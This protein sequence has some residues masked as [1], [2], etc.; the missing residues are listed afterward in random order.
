MSPRSEEAAGRHLVLVGMMA[1]GKTTVGSRLARRLERRFVDSDDQVE[2]RTGRTVRQ[3]FEQDGEDAFR[4]HEAEALAEALGAEEPA[5]I[6]AAGGTVLDEKNR[7][8]MKEGGVVVWLRADPETLADR[9]QRGDHRPL[10]RDDPEGVIRTLD[11]ERHDLYADATHH[12]IDVGT[13]TPD[14]VVEALLVV[15]GAERRAR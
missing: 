7:R 1:T 6:A 2:R 3:I 9:A 14:E 13:R 8:R 12:V 15:L 10:L 4:Q 5:V 11:E